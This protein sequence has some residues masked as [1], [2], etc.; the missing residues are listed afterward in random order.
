MNFVSWQ[1]FHSPTHCC[2]VMTENYFSQKSIAQVNFGGGLDEN[3]RERGR[4]EREER[5][6][7]R[8]KR[9]EKRGEDRRERGRDWPRFWHL[10]FVFGAHAHSRFEPTNK[11]SSLTLPLLENIQKCK[12]LLC[13]DDEKEGGRK[14]R[15]RVEGA[16]WQPFFECNEEGGSCC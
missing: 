8:E 15:P 2:G 3:L 9:R 1:S 4:A 7:E 10:I 11:Q 14:H 12:R 5:G 13:P 6:G 16:K